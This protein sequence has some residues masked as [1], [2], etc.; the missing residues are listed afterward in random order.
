MS[1]T[2]FKQWTL[3]STSGLDSLQLSKGTLPSV[4]GE[5]EIL[6]KFM[7]VS[8]NYRD[9][10]IL[11]GRNPF[12]IAK[13]VVPGSDGA[14]EVIRVGSQVSEFKPGDRVVTTFF[15]SHD[16]GPLSLEIIQSSLGALQDGP[17]REYGIYPQS[18]LIH[19]PPNLSW[20][21]SST[22]SCAGLTAWNALSGLRTLQPGDTVLIQGTGGVSC[23]ALQFAR[24]AGATVIATTSSQVKAEHLKRLGATHILN[25]RD[26]P[27]WGETAKSLTANNIGV[28]IVIQIGGAG[29]IRQSLCAVRL[30][31]VI[32]LVGNLGFGDDGDSPATVAEISQRLATVK[33][34]GVGH[35][36]SFR[37]M[38]RFIETHQITPIL[39]PRHFRLEDLKNAFQYM[40]SPA[41]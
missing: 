25:Y 38:N 27:R 14:G 30:E 41:L 37:E 20:S 12:P 5:N 26:D 13:D 33:S 24:A 1:T 17:F 29:S 2:Q 6:V 22:L 10:I 8:L 31:G 35:K 40:A 36:E 3:A 23:F 11:N 16:S 15:Q 34:I 7:A 32:S 18:G 9:W 21:E 4:L 28:D 39:D 19:A